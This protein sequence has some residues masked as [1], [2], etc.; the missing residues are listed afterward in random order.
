MNDKIEDYIENKAPIELP[1]EN[2][3][4]DLGT[5]VYAHR[6]GLSVTLIMYLLVAICF[7]TAK[8]KLETNGATIN[9]ITIM[10]HDLDDLEQ[11]REE[12]IKSIEALHQNNNDP[13]WS[14]I[15]N[16]AS[17]ENAETSNAISN[18]HMADDCNTDVDQLIK[19]AARAQANMAQN[20]A[21]YESGLAGV[22]AIRD[23][24]AANRDDSWLYNGDLP[25]EVRDRK[26]DGSVTVSYSFNNPV[27]HALILVVPAYQCEGG[28]EVLLRVTI[29]Q[30]GRVLSAKVTSGNDECMQET[31]LAAALISQFDVNTSAP[32]RHT[33]IIHYT[34]VPQNRRNN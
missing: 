10:Q 13:D 7:T 33:G 16:R 32:S 14:D 12:L 29:N 21:D 11:Q 1:F 27:R 3:H 24:A 6:I 31:A 2:E 15:Q 20:R 4:F 5:W 28:G 19:D 18:R 34:F 17:N 9:A 22:Q 26:V 30:E 25:S 8:I 23:D